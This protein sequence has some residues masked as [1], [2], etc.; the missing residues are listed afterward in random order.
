[1]LKSEATE[2]VGV[3]KSGV[4]AL[5][6][7]EVGNRRCGEEALGNCTAREPKSKKRVNS[8]SVKATLYIYS[9]M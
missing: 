6:S 3:L 4:G 7:E 9:I 5:G 1:M 8:I 2:K